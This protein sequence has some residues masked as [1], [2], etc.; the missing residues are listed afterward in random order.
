LVGF[1]YNTSLVVLGSKMAVHYVLH[2]K[3]LYVLLHFFYKRMKFRNQVRLCLAIYNFEAH[4]M[5]SLY[6]TFQGSLPGY[7]YGKNLT[8]NAAAK[9]GISFW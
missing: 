8:P 5:L 1:G 6:L 2:A 9:G 3:S 7:R 4:I